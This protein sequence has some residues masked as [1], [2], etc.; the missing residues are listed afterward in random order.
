MWLVGF[1]F[2]VRFAAFTSTTLIYVGFAKMT[3]SMAMHPYYHEWLTT[4][5]ASCIVRFLFVICLFH[6]FNK[7]PYA[8]KPDSV[9]CFHKSSTIY[10]RC[11]SPV[12]FSAQPPD[13]ERAALYHR[14]TWAF[15]PPGLPE[16]YV[17]IVSCAL[18]PHIFTLT[19][20]KGVAVIFCGT[21]STTFQQY[22]PVR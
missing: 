13:I 5:G 18:L 22:L 8:Y 12:I 3:L 19:A 1:N 20:P 17:A 9:F 11:R 10:L 7:K 15:N 4:V 14:Y 16:V 21:V 6:F 2:V